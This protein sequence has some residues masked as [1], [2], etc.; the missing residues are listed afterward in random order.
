VEIQVYNA[1]VFKIELT[2]NCMHASTDDRKGAYVVF[3]G[4]IAGISNQSKQGVDTGLQAHSETLDG[5]PDKLQ[6]NGH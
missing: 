3:T 2:N 1:S 5:G 6:L 4:R